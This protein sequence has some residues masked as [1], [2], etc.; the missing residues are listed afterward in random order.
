[1]ATQEGKGWFAIKIGGIVD[2]KTRIP[3]YLIRALVLTHRGY[4]I[5][6]I[7]NM[8]KY[9]LEKFSAEKPG[10][11]EIALLALQIEQF[12]TSGI[13]FSGIRALYKKTF[14]TD[15]FNDFLAMWP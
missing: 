1:M 7:A 15:I 3:N 14:A 11:P 12:R 6:I 13:D 4:S 2:W 8:M 10:D 9:R 5:E